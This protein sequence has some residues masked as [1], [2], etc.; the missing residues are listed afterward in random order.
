MSAV[1]LAVLRPEPTDVP[2]FYRWYEAEHVTGRL[3][4]DGFDDAHRYRTDDDFD[5]GILVYE[6]DG[7]PALSTPEYRDLQART[8]EA[9][10]QRMGALRQFVRVTGQV[11]QE[12][13]DAVGPA[14]MLFVVAF[15]APAEDLELLDAWYRDEH[16]PALLECKEWLGVRLIDVADSNTGWTR[17]ALHRLADASALTSP[18]RQAAADTPG[19]HRLVERPWFGQSA[20]F[21]AHAVDRFDTPEPAPRG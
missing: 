1:L 14:P 19:R 15:A 5:R 9:T 11:V 4:V 12:H 8:A 7:L 13:G 6:L 18:E 2:D 10:Q 17:V 20:R 3:A 16:A 21:V